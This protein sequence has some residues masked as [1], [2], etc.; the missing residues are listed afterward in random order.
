MHEK[1]GRPIVNGFDIKMMAKS[2]AIDF[3]SQILGTV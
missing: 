1:F 3:F 2:K